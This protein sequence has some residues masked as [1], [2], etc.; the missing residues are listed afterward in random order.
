MK[1]IFHNTPE[2]PKVDESTPTMPP[3]PSKMNPAPEATAA[4]LL[5][6]ARTASYIPKELPLPLFSLGLTDSS[7][8]ETQ[9]QEVV[10]QEKLSPETTILIEELDVLVE[11]IAK[12]GEKKTPDFPEGKTLQLKSKPWA[13]L[14]TNLKL[15]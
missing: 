2:P 6:M 8:E 11:M 14:L 10:G 12:S 13:R 7:Q 15:L 9:T 4:T 5:M 1:L 3:T